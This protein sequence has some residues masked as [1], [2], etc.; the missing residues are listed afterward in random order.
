M[1]TPPVFSAGAVLTAGQMN[2]VG[3]WLVSE[4]SFSATA[5][6]ACQ[7]V[8]TSDFDSYRLVA[9][10]TT[11][12][13]GAAQIQVQMMVGATP[14]A[15]A[16]YNYYFRGITWAGAN[17]NTAGSAGGNWFIAR[18][19]GG[20]WSMVMDLINPNLAKN[21]FVTTQGT[22]TSLQYQCG[23]YHNST[24]QFD[25]IQFYNSGAANMTGTVKIYGYR[26]G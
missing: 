14:T 15:G 17:D 2:K 9:S 5:T 24:T 10:C 25:G 8:F 11:G 12:A 1:A 19:N 6:W 22:D 26:E 4:K 20:E 3:L 16:G 7:S 13:G 21:T 23:G 18:T